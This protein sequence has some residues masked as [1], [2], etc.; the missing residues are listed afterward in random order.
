MSESQNQI[1]A[2]QPR[3]HLFA[4]I[5]HFLFGGSRTGSLAF[6]TALAASAIGAATWVLNN[7][8]SSPQH[9]SLPK[10]V[11]LAVSFA[12]GFLIG[13]IVRGF[14]KTAALIAAVAVA[15]IGLSTHLT[16]DQETNRAIKQDATWIREHVTHAKTHLLALLPSTAGAAFGA[17]FGSRRTRPRDP[18]P[19]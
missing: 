4:R 12:G 1:S 17:F 10:Y 8:K 7:L 2:P 6:L 14:A 15:A 11:S 3:P 9:T 13:R 19:S 16:A 5:L 18:D